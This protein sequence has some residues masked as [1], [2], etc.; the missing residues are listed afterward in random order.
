VRRAT[1][2]IRQTP[3]GD[4]D[5]YC[6]QWVHAAQ[7]EMDAFGVTLDYPSADPELAYTVFVPWQSVV[8]I[9]WELCSCHRCAGFVALREAA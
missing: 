2:L 6:R 7:L 3:E 1:V 9:E 8:Q 5:G 4:E